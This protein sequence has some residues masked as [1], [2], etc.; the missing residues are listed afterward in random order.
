MSSRGSV[1]AVITARGGS[2]GLVGKNI[3]LLGGLPLVAWSVRAALSAR[4][5]SRTILST[6]DVAIAAVARDHGCEVPFMRSA[7]LAADDTPSI[8]V[9]LDALEKVSGFEIVVLLQ[10]TSPLRTAED[11]DNAIRLCV[12]SGAPACVS[13]CEVDKSP[14]WMYRLDQQARMRPLM[15][16]HSVA[17][18]RQDLP[19]VHVLNGAVY[20]TRADVLMRERTF[21]PEGTIGYVMPRVRSIDI[22]SELDLFIAERLITDSRNEEI[23]PS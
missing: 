11:I 13:V 17:S 6:D 8:D 16:E 23:S 12:D 14:Y 2:K 10:P 19:P 5:V 9:V 18:R 3:R 7:Q 15:A 20:V 4:L 22:D 1:L 21:I